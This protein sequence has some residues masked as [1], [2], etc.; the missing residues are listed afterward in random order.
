MALAQVLHSSQ[1]GLRHS[2]QILKLSSSP[3]RLKHTLHLVLSLEPEPEPEVVELDVTPEMTVEGVVDDGV[4]AS[5]SL[6]LEKIK[7]EDTGENLIIFV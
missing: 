2:V 6:E 3:I 1:T 4:P 5:D 7:R